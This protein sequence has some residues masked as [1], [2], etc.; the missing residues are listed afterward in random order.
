MR[1]FLTPQISN[2]FFPKGANGAFEKA[3]DEIFFKTCKQ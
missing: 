2:G 3:T 1:K